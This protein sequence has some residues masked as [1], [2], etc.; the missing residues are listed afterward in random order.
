MRNKDTARPGGWQARGRARAAA[1]GG[2]AVTSILPARDVEVEPALRHDGR[3]VGAFIRRAGDG[4]VILRKHVDPTKHMLRQPAA[5]AIAETHCL[6]LLQLG[7]VGVEL[8]AA[9][10]RRWWASTEAFS[11]HALRIERDVDTQ[12][13]LPLRWWQADGPDGRQ[14]SFDFDALLGTAGGAGGAR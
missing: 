8:L 13:A 3:V 12:L 14:L 1:L 9:D 10:G 11:R 6:R 4:R 5:W 2:G 7:G